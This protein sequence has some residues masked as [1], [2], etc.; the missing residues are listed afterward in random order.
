MSIQVVFISVIIQMTQYQYQSFYETLK[1]QNQ[2]V[3]F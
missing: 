2:A 3:E 1:K